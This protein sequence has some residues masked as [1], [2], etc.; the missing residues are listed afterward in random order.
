MVQDVDDLIQRF[1]TLPFTA[2][3]GGPNSTPQFKARAAEVTTL[4]LDRFPFLA[5][6]PDYMYFLARYGGASGGEAVPV[7]VGGPTETDYYISIH[8][9]TEANSA[10]TEMPFASCVDSNGL[11]GFCEVWHRYRPWSQGNEWRDGLVYTWISLE[12][13]GKRRRGVY[14]QWMI[15]DEK[16]EYSDKP[17]E[18]VAGTFSEWLARFIDDGG[19]MWLPAE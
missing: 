10:Y 7:D 17:G 18:F 5:E 4:F 3:S 11:F 2:V 15:D 6:Y 16:G 14:A 8:G 12:A 9:Y 13:A 1:K 19:R